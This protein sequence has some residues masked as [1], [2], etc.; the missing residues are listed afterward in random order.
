[1]ISKRLIFCAMLTLT[2]MVCNV[3]AHAISIDQYFELTITDV[4]VAP[5]S[6]S[7]YAVGDTISGHVTFDNEGTEM[8]GYDVNGDIEY[9]WTVSSSF[10][11]F[12]D[13]VFHFDFAMPAAFQTYSP[14]SYYDRAYHHNSFDRM[15]YDFEYIFGPS[16]FISLFM[17]SS[18]P[19]YLFGTGEYCISDEEGVESLYTF[20]YGPVVQQPIEPVPEPSTILL[21][22][23]GLVG[24]CVYRKK[25]RS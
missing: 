21:L 20:D 6:P 15:Y 3:P 4:D 8:H 13:A 19:S 17:Y 22:G 9:T 16:T 12:S 2:L 18:D 1:M 24:I 7:F 25:Y 23:C 5:S 11:F 10:S 14:T